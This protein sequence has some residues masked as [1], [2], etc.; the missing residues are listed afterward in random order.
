MRVL[1][2][3]RLRGAL[4]LLRATAPP[5]RLPPPRVHRARATQTLFGEKGGGT[6][7]PE[8]NV[9]GAP[10]DRLKLMRRPA[11]SCPPSSLSRPR[12]ARSQPACFHNTGRPEFSGTTRPREATSGCVIDAEARTQVSTDGATKPRLH[13]RRHQRYR[14]PAIPG[15]RAQ[16]HAG[17][18]LPANPPRLL[19]VRGSSAWRRWPADPHDAPPDRGLERF[20]LE[21]VPRRGRREL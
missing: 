8:Q 6:S 11:C 4:P 16:K 15:P 10:R 21:R 12:P 14:P 5:A 17:G 13:R 18:K 19:H 1:S 3:T 7:T 20:Y 9:Q 2:A